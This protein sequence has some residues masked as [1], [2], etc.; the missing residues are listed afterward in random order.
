VTEMRTRTYI[1]PATR[2]GLIDEL[3]LIEKD[4]GIHVPKS[5]LTLLRRTG[6]TSQKIR[7]RTNLEATK[8]LLKLPKGVMEYLA[9]PASYAPLARFI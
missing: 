5:A 7:Q 2:R 3:S 6:K 1:S 4:A 9:D 8:I